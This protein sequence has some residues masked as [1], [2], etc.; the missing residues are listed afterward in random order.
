MIIQVPVDQN[1][2]IVSTILRQSDGLLTTEPL[3]LDD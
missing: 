3:A 2:S 1:G